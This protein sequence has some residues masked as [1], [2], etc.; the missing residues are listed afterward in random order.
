FGDELTHEDT[1]SIVRYL[2][3]LANVPERD[4]PERGGWAERNYR[5]YCASCH[6]VDGDGD[7]PAAGRLD[8]EPRNFRN[9]QWAAGQSAEDLAKTIGTGRPGTAMPPFAALLTEDERTRL[10]KYV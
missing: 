10:A 2:R 4:N 1:T 7:G 6:G 3:Q 9:P 5:A 8:P